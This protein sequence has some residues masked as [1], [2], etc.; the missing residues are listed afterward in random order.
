MSD[1]NNLYRLEFAAMREAFGV[2][3]DLVDRPNV[4]GPGSTPW[5][6]VMYQGKR[7]GWLPAGTNINTVIYQA[8][9]WLHQNRQIRQEAANN[10]MPSLASRLL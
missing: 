1:L 10:N 3:V 6:R 7:I 9:Q 2:Q 5:L 4:H 8:R